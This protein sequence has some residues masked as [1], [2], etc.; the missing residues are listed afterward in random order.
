MADNYSHQLRW[1]ALNGACA[2]I[3]SNTVMGKITFKT[4]LTDETAINRTGLGI[5]V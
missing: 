2:L 5:K 1:C 3:T 4:K